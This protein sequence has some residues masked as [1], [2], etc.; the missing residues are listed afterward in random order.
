MLIT[1]TALAVF[2]GILLGVLGGND[3]VLLVPVLL[4]V[5]A[6]EPK[7]ALSTSQIILAATSCVAMLAH[8]R[9]GHVIFRTG[10]LFGLSGMI[11]AY[12]GGRT[13]HHVPARLLLLG[14]V[15][16]M[17][18]SGAQM[19]RRRTP[20]DA[21]VAQERPQSKAWWRG[22]AVGLG[23]GFIAGMLGAGGGFLI[24]P[25]LLFFGGLPMPQAIGTSLLVIAMQSFAGALGYLGHVNVEWRLAALLGGTMAVAS[26]GGSLLSRHLPAAMLRKLFAALLI[27]VAIFMLTRIIW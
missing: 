22:A 1:A 17:V 23:T 11:G 15:I 7:S 24:V 2:I 25:A 19:L 26:I 16:L 4:Y 3:S 14:F 21:E 9:A 5:L 12:L 13:A 20:K 10:L 27:G 6:L 18:A 8:A